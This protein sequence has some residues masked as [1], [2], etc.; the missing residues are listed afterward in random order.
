MRFADSPCF[1]WQPEQSN[2]SAVEELKARGWATD[3]WAGTDQSTTNSVVFS[4]TV[5]ATEA[6]LQ[7]WEAV[8]EV[9]IQF[10][11]MLRYGSCLRG[12]WSGAL[13]GNRQGFEVQRLSHG[14]REHW[15]TQG[16][17]Y[18][19][20]C[21]EG[22]GVARPVACCSVCRHQGCGVRL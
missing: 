15:R 5:T 8:V 18:T 20:F 13:D 16:S 22:G 2:G 9:F 1:F 11:N 12:C 7:N 3:V 6:G 17:V 14:E 19:R 21:V 10:I 4:I